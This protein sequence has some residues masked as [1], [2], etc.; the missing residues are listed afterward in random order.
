MRMSRRLKQRNKNKPIK[1]EKRMKEEAEVFRL[2]KPKRKGIL[3]LIFSRFF[4]IIL[5]LLLELAVMVVPFVMLENYM[6]HF[7][8]ALT[9][10]S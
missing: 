2:A 7:Y 10:R 3:A 4:I 6:H 8:G 1:K 9:R 5:L